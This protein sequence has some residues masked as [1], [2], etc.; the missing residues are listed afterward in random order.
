MNVTAGLESIRIRFGEAE[1][2][3]VADEMGL[4]LNLAAAHLGGPTDEVLFECEWAEQ[5]VGNNFSFLRSGGCMAGIA[6]VEC[7]MEEIESVS[8]QLYDELLVHTRGLSLQRLWNFVPRIN[9]ESLGQEVY[10]SFNAGRWK[11]FASVYGETKMDVRLPAATAV[12]LQEGVSRLALMFLAGDQP[13]EYFEN[14]RQTPAYQYPSEFGPRSP[15]FARASVVSCERGELGYLSGTSSI[16][17]SETVGQ[18]DL[19]KQFSETMEN[20]RV[21]MQQMGFA[22]GWDKMADYSPQLRVYV[23][24]V[25]DY[26]EISERLAAVV[27]AGVLAQT[28]FIQADICRQPLKLEIEGVFRK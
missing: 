17:G 8:E 23:R 14:P 21:A 19:G 10:R 9:D 7:G 11:A 6:V 15:S 3:C 12:G 16:C 24:D 4:Q 25:E 27:G 22:G 20:I 13:V 18:G 5:E 1:T 26:A 2:V 28:V